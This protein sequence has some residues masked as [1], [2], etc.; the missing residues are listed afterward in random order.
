MFAKGSKRLEVLLTPGSLPGGLGT[1]T[2]LRSHDEPSPQF[3][4][5]L[6]FLGL[7]EFL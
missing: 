4:G 3:I 5:E 7:P 2:Y 6:S 1:L